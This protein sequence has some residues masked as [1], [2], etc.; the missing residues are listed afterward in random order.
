MSPFDGTHLLADLHG[1][2]RLDEPA[3]IERA[4]RAAVAGAGATLLGLK[5]HHFGGCQG[6]TGVALLAESHVS[7]HTWPE[8]RYAAVDI[9]LCSGRAHVER[10][11]EALTTVLAPQCCETQL[12]ARGYSSVTETSAR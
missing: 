6:V 9:F 7:I 2:D 3:L 12:I 4:L 8:H 5:L 10:A 1:C 11:I